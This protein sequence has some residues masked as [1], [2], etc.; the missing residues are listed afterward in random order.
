M[1]TYDM[2][3]PMDWK[4]FRTMPKDL[5]SEYIAGIQDRFGV[6]ACV[7]SKEMSGLSGAALPQHLAR[8]GLTYS[9]AYKGTR[10]TGASRDVWES[11]L[12][13]DTALANVAEEAVLDTE[14]AEPV[15]IDKDEQEP[16]ALSHIVVE[17]NGEFDPAGFLRYISQ[18]QMPSGKV[19]VRLEVT[20]E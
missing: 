8:T 11:W 13:Q 16:F 19:H 10:L 5:Q 4:T 7:I 2:N 15:E 18:F 12:A 1:V 14:A 6:G 20:A 17:F 3:L 9:S